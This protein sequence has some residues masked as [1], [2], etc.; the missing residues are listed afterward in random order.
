VARNQGWTFILALL[1]G[2]LLAS[3]YWLYGPHF[4]G[5]VERGVA[6][7]L[8][9][10]QPT[11]ELSPGGGIPQGLPSQAAGSR[12]QLV[13]GPREVFLADLKEGRVWRYFHHTKEGGFA[14][15][16]EGFLP[17]PMFFGGK[18]FYSAT[19][20]DAPRP[21]EPLPVKPGEKKAP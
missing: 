10:Q 13:A 9:A 5:Q 20:V 2:A 3:L 1:A 19:E 14:K 8:K 11:L 17:V 7:A 15:E 18:K 6:Q 12:Y 21:P 16:D 4:K